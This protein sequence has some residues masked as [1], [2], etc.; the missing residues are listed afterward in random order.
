MTK[1]IRNNILWSIAV[2]CTTA[3]LFS[4][5]NDAKEVRDF[6]ADKNLPITE[7]RNISHIRTDSGRVDIRMKASLMRDFSNRKDHPYSDFPEGVRITSI[8]KEGDSVTIE[9]DYAISFSKTGVSEIRD[10]VVILNHSNKNR[11]ETTQLFWDK[12]T[13]MFFTEK[14]FI[15]FTP[16]DTVPGRGFESDESL[17]QWW[18]KNLSNG[19]VEIKNSEL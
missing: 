8:D 12:Q 17:Q 2:V 13:G 7:A 19:I 9:G 16:T 3:M 14:N 5:T 10:N 4:C 18:V 15:L 6:L 11:L 1:S